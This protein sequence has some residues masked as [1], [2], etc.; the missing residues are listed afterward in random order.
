MIFKTGGMNITSIVL[1]A[2]DEQT[3]SSKAQSRGVQGRIRAKTIDL[4]DSIKV[5]C[6]SK[7][8]RHNSVRDT[9]AG[10]VR[11]QGLRAHVPYAFRPP[12]RDRV[13]VASGSSTSP[14]TPSLQMAQGN[15]SHDSRAGERGQGR[16]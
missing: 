8:S 9:S 12:L 14:F 2:N 7:E 3:G 6:E 13:D 16:R 15:V 10:A 5:V 1:L 4:R 11:L